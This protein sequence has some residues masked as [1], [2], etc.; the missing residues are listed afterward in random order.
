MGKLV[1]LFQLVEQ[2]GED[3]R[4]TTQTHALNSTCLCSLEQGDF[5]I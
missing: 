4:Q 5:K 2:F 3:D 1:L